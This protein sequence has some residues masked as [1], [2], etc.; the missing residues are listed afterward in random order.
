MNLST[1]LNPMAIPNR[2]EVGLAPERSPSVCALSRPLTA[3]AQRTAAPAIT[4]AGNSVAD[5]VALIKLKLP[6]TDW[7]N[8][9][10]VVDYF[11]SI[12]YP[13]EG[14]ANLDLY[15]TSAINFLNTL[16]N[17]VTPSA[18]SGLSMAGNPPPYDIRVRGMVAM[19]LTLQRFQEQ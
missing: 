6:A 2:P 10:V 1:V 5:P 9:G 14:K 18:F 11:L 4:D 17:G 7:S 15:R 19:L 16:D 12:L 3:P 8:A 13:G